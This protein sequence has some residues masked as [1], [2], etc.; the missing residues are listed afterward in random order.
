MSKTLRYLSLP[1][2]SGSQNSIPDSWV[3][4]LQSVGFTIDKSTDANRMFWKDCTF[5]LKILNNTIMLVRFGTTD[6]V[7]TNVMQNLGG[8]PNITFTYY[9]YGEGL[10]FGFVPTGT[11]TYLVGAILPPRHLGELNVAVCNNLIA[12]GTNTPTAVPSPQS[13]YTGCLTSDT[14]ML[15]KIFDSGANSF[16]DDVYLSSVNPLAQGFAS[17]R[18][19]ISGKDILL[20]RIVNNNANTRLFGFDMALVPE[21]EE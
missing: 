1:T 19:T 10:I 8:T 13:Y 11:N 14:V 20:L 4:P 2:I 6:V 5:C 3:E 9:P 17:Y 7:I 16:R 21:D 15:E 18:A 12:M